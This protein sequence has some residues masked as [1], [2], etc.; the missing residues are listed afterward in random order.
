MNNTPTPD[1]AT[2]QTSTDRISGRHG[3]NDRASDAQTLTDHGPPI[4][5]TSAG[6]TA[7]P[8]I[9]PP[10][11]AAEYRPP[12]HRLLADERRELIERAAAR[13]FA[14]RGYRT[15]TVEEI[16]AAA[17][18]SKPMLYR[19]F[20]SKKQLYMR[21]L[22]RR[23]DEL[24]AAALDGYL[25]KDATLGQRLRAMVDAWFAH[26]DEHPD[27]SKLLLLDATEDPEIQALQSELRGLQRAADMALTRELAPGLPEA[28]LEPLGEIV[29]S[30]L[31]GLALWWLEHPDVPRETLVATV[32]RVLKGVLLTVR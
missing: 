1:A 23:R 28:E 4:P 3:P 14:E 12:K 20:E 24:A 15:T 27:T 31:T 32:M 2:P 7:V 5:R 29:R 26:V 10:W 22:E 18:V 25:R 8:A 11:A 6:A 17:D 13:L 30:S 16:V 9:T 19:H 21:L